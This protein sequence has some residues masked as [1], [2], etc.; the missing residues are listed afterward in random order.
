MFYVPGSFIAK[1]KIGDNI[2][3]NLSV[4]EV[5]YN[6]KDSLPSCQSEILNKPIIVIIVSVCEAVIYDFIYRSHNFTSEGIDGLTDE[7]LS[8]LR[9]RNP[10]NMEK[11]INLIR[12]FDLLQAEDKSYYDKL[13][14]L[15][16]LRN[17]IHIQNEKNKLEADE[18]HAFTKKRRIEAEQVLELLM[19]RIN[20][21]YPRPNHIRASNF[22]EKF[23]LPWTQHYT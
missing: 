22:V 13:G 20:E 18:A 6:A 23:K 16:L 4:L 12:E 5:L 11:K 1:F 19:T 10:K 15:T 7:C 2:R 21:L 9:K 14:T 8:E 17:R 3:Y